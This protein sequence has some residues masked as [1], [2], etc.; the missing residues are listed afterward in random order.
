LGIPGPYDEDW[1]KSRD[2]T[3]LALE[4]WIRSLVTVKNERAR[5]LPPEGIKPPVEGECEERPASRP[6]EQARGGKSLWD[7]KGGEWRWSPE[8][9]W[10]ND[11]WDYNPHTRPDSPWENVPHGGKPPVKERP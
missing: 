2:A 3:A 8:N 5:G 7:K 1:A 6:S 9:K 11:H 4:D 10:H